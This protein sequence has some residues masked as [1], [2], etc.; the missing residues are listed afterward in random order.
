MYE[1]C[2]II[3]ADYLPYAKTLLHSLRQVHKEVFLHVLIGDNNV[4]GAQEPGLQLYAEEAILKHSDD[5]RNLK[6][7]YADANIDAYRWSLKPVFLK[8]LMTE[9]SATNIIYTDCDIFFFNSFEFLFQKLETSKVLLTPHWRSSNPFTDAKN[10]KL[11]YTNGLYNAGFLG[12]NKTSIEVLDWWAKACYFICEKNPQIGQFV[13]QTHLNLMPIYFE[14]VEVIKHR[15]CNV[16][17]WN[18]AECKRVLK[19]GHEVL[20]NGLD[21]VVFIHFTG[22]TVRGILNNQDGLLRP[23]LDVYADTLKQFGIDIRETFAAEPEKVN[24]SVLRRI[25]NK[26]GF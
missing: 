9:G 25:K 18:Q 3:T 26:L 4:A 24:K 16:A 23:Y 19:N 13:D 21:E 11:L 1:F 17:N 14:G 6:Q 8:Y 22:S 2:T 10:F 7:K 12:A 15:G 5:A 20:I